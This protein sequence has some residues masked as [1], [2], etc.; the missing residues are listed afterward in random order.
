MAAVDV[1]GCVFGCVLFRLGK[2]VSAGIYLGRIVQIHILF[3]FEHNIYI[4]ID[5]A[6]YSS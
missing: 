3:L 5:A 4:C 1:V 6:C 2:F